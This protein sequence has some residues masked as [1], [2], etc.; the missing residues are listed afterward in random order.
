LQRSMAVLMSVLGQTAPLVAFPAYSRPDQA[1]ALEY[2]KLVILRKIAVVELL[3]FAR[4]W[5]NLR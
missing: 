1:A 2:E 4:R 5:H 3:R